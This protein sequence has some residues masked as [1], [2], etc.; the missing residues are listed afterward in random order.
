MIRDT[1][2]IA[3]EGDDGTGKSTLMNTAFDFL[4]SEGCKVLK[5]TNQDLPPYAH[6]LRNII[7]S[8]AMERTS[9]DVRALMFSSWLLNIQEEGVQPNW[10]RYDFILIDRTYM[11][12]MAYQQDSIVLDIYSDYMEQVLPVDIL[13]YL[14]V[15]GLTGI[16]RISK[17]RGETLDVFE[18]SSTSFEV[19]RR[20]KVYEQLIENTTATHV[21]R[22][23]A[24]GTLAEV[25]ASFKESFSTIMGSEDDL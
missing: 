5:I 17:H 18:T 25:A 21:I 10:G 16:E 20:K 11:S 3:F 19:E 8:P 6:S 2:L 4:V 12:T 7:T 15:D 23:D 9:A 1:K 24:N 14:E 22:L 13:V